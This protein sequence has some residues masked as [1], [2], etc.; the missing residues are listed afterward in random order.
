[1]CV[2]GFQAAQVRTW[3]TIAAVGLMATFSAA[4]PVEAAKFR[5]LSFAVEQT[6]RGEKSF[7]A[8]QPIFGYD[9]K[10]S[11]D[12]GLTIHVGQDQISAKVTAFGWGPRRAEIGPTTPYVATNAAGD[13]EV[14]FRRS[15]LSETYTNSKEGLHHSFTV[16][17][18]TSSGSDSLWIEYSIG[19]GTRVQQSG[20]ESIVVSQGARRFTYAGLKAWDAAGQSVPVSMSVS[21]QKINFLV[22]DR[23]ARY[24]VTI[25]PTWTVQQTLTAPD[26]VSGD[27][28][29]VATAVSGD[30]A[31]IGANL[32]GTRRG[33]AYVYVR[34]AGVWKYLQTLTASDAKVDD[35]YGTSVA[36]DG[37][38]LAV[39]SP[40]KAAS[41]GAVYVYARTNSEWNFQQKLTVIDP[42][43]YS[44]LGYS[45]SI[46]GDSLLVSADAQG[47]NRGSAYVFRRTGDVWNQEQK[48]VPKD[49]VADDSFS[50]SLAISG[51]SAIIGAQGQNK[52]LGAAYL[53]T[54]TGSVWTQ[55]QKFLAS[56]GAAG[57][58]YGY[59]VSISG[60]TI[61]IGAHG[62]NSLEGIVYV[63]TKNG[64]N[65]IETRV[66]PL[67]FKKCSV[68][69]TTVSLDGDTLLVGGRDAKTAGW[70]WAFQ[71]DGLNWV[72]QAKFSRPDSFGQD[73]FGQALSIKG[74]TAIFGSEGA[75][76]NRGDASVVTFTPNRLTLSIAPASL[77]GGQIASGTVTMS[78]PAPAG[79]TLVHLSDDQAAL[80]VPATVLVP[81]GSVSATFDVSTTRINAPVTAIVTAAAPGDTGT[82]TTVAINPG[83]LS[84][85]FDGNTVIG[86]NPVNGTVTISPDF[87]ASG[88]VI[89]L[90]SNSATAV[91]PATVTIAEGQT[92]AQFSISTSA[93]NG[94]TPVA[95][96]ASALGVVPTSAGFNVEPVSF[97]VALDPSSVYGGQSVNAKITLTESAPKGGITVTLKS[98]QAAL[99]APATIIIPDGSRS[100]SLTLTTSFVTS[101][102]GA[103]L[104][105]TTN[106]GV[107]ASA[108]LAINPGTIQ[109]ALNA[110]TVTGGGSVGGTVSISPASVAS[111]AV[112]SLVSDSA[113]VVVP[114]KVTIAKGATSA[115]FTVTTLPVSSNV[116]ASILATARG[117]SSAGSLATLTVQPN[118]LTL[119]FDPA[120]VA[121]GTTVRGTV[122]LSDP[123][124]KGGTLVALQG[125]PKGL[126]I[127]T[128]VKIPEGTT[129]ATFDVPTAP[130]GSDVVVNLT[131]AA[132]GSTSSSAEFSVLAPVPSSIVLANSS[133][134][135]G[136]TTA[137][138]VQLSGPAPAGGLLVSLNS[139]AP[140][141]AR[142][143]VASVLVPGGSATVDTTV[144]TFAVTDAT[145][146]NLSASL[147]GKSVTQS[148][149]VV[150]RT[151]ALKI[152]PTTVLG[153]DGTAV[154]GTIT[155]DIAAPAAGIV[156]TLTADDGSVDVPVTVT[157]PAK[158]K[159]VAFNIGHRAVA[160]QRTV[161]IRMTS[162]AGGASAGLTIKPNQVK[163]LVL[164]PKTA[165]G[166]SSTVVTGTV[167]LAGPAGTG[168]ATVLLGSDSGYALV[169]VTVL[170]PAGQTSATFTVKHKVVPAA[171]TATISASL[172]GATVAAT[173][174]LTP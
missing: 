172:G 160:S 166:G 136:N 142:F 34:T 24:P 4:G 158:A 112:V 168:G 148:L 23:T 20:P 36:I 144:L 29:G 33:A 40:N 159:A 157:L 141:V 64:A 161:T 78:A 153:G 151:I 152:A 137:A 147:N 129:S 41:K 113:I 54:R 98:D 82:S 49:A 8:R 61:A 150:P 19:L 155:S 114:S 12:A 143:G 167:T 39:S 117:T 110:T 63:Y 87:L 60:D 140:S 55:Q 52:S 17:K 163:S 26:G 32:R 165:K 7:R 45:I 53:F 130:V 164:T 43:T 86:G 85:T 25:D 37:D 18:R 72:Q 133:L 132:V 14:Q 115:T 38:Y 5:G 138:T 77:Y 171:T 1:M 75:S 131:A 169:G 47:K 123:A 3:L 2:S 154:K 59:S 173:L 66:Q 11:R 122:K 46:S 99:T 93:V 145:T 156:F 79:G 42:S 109:I 13:P 10:L 22:D 134:T 89:S 162:T 65:W 35:Y 88:A 84:L 91:P 121:G 73:H 97:S 149:V 128:S 70:A 95:I 57:N 58:F 135:G 100:V 139:D 9:I 92:S 30:T 124:V 50:W 76:N 16:A 170:V 6:S 62:H 126:L 106:Q 118:V 80:S 102:V 67:D 125:D 107:T 90:T 104:T 83:T 28:F 111:E 15:V 146:V 127:P 108:N 21:G 68:F 174:R 119:T 27:R 48:I 101:P 56:D 51:N 96:Q 94:E 105:A 81:E 74:S 71:R 103:K 44:S 69:G 116:V 120:K 31:V